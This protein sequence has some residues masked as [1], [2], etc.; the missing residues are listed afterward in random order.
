MGGQFE[1]QPPTPHLE[2][3]N[4]KRREKVWTTLTRYKGTGELKDEK[5][6]AVARLKSI[7]DETPTIKSFTFAVESVIEDPD[8]FPHYLTMEHARP[9]TAAASLS[10]TSAAHH[11]AQ[12]PASASSSSRAITAFKFKPGQW[13]DFFVPHIQVV[14][15]FSLAS[16][17]LTLTHHNTFTL[18]I[19][20]AHVNPV[21]RYLHESAQPGDIV[22]VRVGGSFHLDD[23]LPTIPR[24]PSGPRELILIAGGVGATP[25]ISIASHVVECNLE[26]AQQGRPPLYRALM[27]Y[28]ARQSDELLFRDKLYR[29]SNDPASGL[30]MRFFVTRGDDE[31]RR[32]GL[33]YGRMAMDDLV[34]DVE[35]ARGRLGGKAWPTIYMCGPSVLERAVVEALGDVGFPMDGLKFEQWW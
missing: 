19:K 30:A 32:E 11:P 31:E 27:C 8:L 20:R 9:A 33:R 18:A 29:L 28:S 14:G 4:T 17:P 35:E 22:Q 26:R 13:V 10:R 16:S 5:V 12:R 34:R 24:L 7:R 25:I 3:T 21:V 15:G 1:G 23:D 6:R 2:L